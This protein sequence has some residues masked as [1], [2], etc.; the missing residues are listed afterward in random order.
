MLY[1]VGHNPS[2]I[3]S[4]TRQSGAAFS[5]SLAYRTSLCKF[6]LDFHESISALCCQQSLSAVFHQPGGLLRPSPHQIFQ[7]FVSGC[8]D[9]SYQ[10]NQAKS[11]NGKNQIH[12]RF[13]SSKKKKKKIRKKSN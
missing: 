4:T 3:V 11:R 10:R 1:S 6:V 5:V 9:A 2:N 12:F 7:A 13:F 8:R